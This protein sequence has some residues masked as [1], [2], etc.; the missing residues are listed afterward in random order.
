MSLLAFPS[1]NPRQQL[2]K[3]TNPAGVYLSRLAAGSRPTMRSGLEQIVAMVNQWTGQGFD[4]L[5]FPWGEL[6]YQHTQAIRSQLAERYA[7]STANKILSALRGVIKEAWRLGMIGVEDYQR[8]VDLQPIKGSRPLKGRALHQDEI[9]ALLQVCSNDQSPHGV[10]DAAMLALLRS[11]GLRRSEVVKLEVKDVN[12]GDRSITIR[13]AKGNKTRIVPLSSHLLPRLEYWLQLRSET[14]IGDGAL[15][16][17]IR[18]SK[19]TGE[20]LSDQTVGDMLARRCKE[21]GI[22][23]ETTTHDFRRTMCSNL[24]SAGIDIATVAKIAG[25]ASVDVT[26]KYD[27]RNEEL[28][29]K[30]VESLGL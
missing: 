15:F 8:A 30:A 25:H 18:G 20:G 4:M 12:L 19:I 23:Q 3:S 24:L 2:A 1:D 28:S 27:R 11:C 21:A 29:R 5:S 22:E 16:V 14:G 9:T 6:R 7:H 10:R 26:K 17:R 13:G